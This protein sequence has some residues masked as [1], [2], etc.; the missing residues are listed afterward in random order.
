MELVRLSADLGDDDARRRL[1]HW[2][3]WLRERATS[4]DDHARQALAK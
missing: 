2:L 3:T 4:G 1:A